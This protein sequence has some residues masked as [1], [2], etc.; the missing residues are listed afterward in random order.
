MDRAE[1]YVDHS[2]VDV[3]R[4]LEERAREVG[5]WLQAGDCEAVKAGC[6]TF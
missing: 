1:C 2:L 3:E 5:V 4:H 6:T